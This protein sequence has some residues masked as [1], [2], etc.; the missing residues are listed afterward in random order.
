MLFWTK[1]PFAFVDIFILFRLC[2]FE[3]TAYSIKRAFLGIVI[4]MTVLDVLV[5]MY[6][7]MLS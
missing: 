1:L 5:L 6:I 2:M 4:V 3:F 7:D